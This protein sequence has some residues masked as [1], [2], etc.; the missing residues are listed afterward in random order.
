MDG[1]K[2]L[3]WLGKT[4]N[5]S[6]PW[7][8]TRNVSST[9]RSHSD[10]L[11]CRVKSKFLKMLHEDVAHNG[12]QGAS[13]SHAIVLLE[14]LVHLKIW[15]D[16]P[17]FLMFCRVTFDGF[18]RNT[19]IEVLLR[20]SKKCYVNNVREILVLK[21]QKKSMNFTRKYINHFVSLN[22]QFTLSISIWFYFS[23]L[24]IGLSKGNNTSVQL[25]IYSI[26]L[27][28]RQSTYPSIHYPPTYLSSCLPVRLFTYPS[29]QL[30]IYPPFFHLQLRYV[31]FI[32]YAK[33]SI[34]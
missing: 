30:P 4:C 16:A 20:Q 18:L 28:N 22:V 25:P 15:V 9:Y 33:L 23:W 2:I 29:V 27:L 24:Y 19:T 3:R 17:A 31:Y 8:Q 5:R 13:H 34:S 6:G 26:R 10:G 32:I 7:G 12:W 21:S 11:L 1:V 14:A